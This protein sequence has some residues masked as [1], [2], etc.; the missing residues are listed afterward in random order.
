MRFSSIE[1][2]NYRQYRN[3]TLDFNKGKHDLHVIVG[4]NGTGKTNLLNAFTWCLYGIE[5]HLGNS[6]KHRGEPKLN[7]DTISDAL[8]R[9][10]DNATI[11]VEIELELDGETDR[12]SRKLPV[13]IKSK[14]DILEKKSSESF[15][16]QRMILGGQ[17]IVLRDEAASS[18]IERK[19]PE[20]IREYFFFD[21][22]QLSNYFSEVRS[23]AIKAAIHSIS[24]ID[25]VTRMRERTENTVKS[26][27]RGL[28]ASIPN[29]K[30]IN[31]DIEKYE[32]ERDAIQTQIDFL[33]EQSRK[34]KLRITELNEALRGV[35]DLAK[36]ESDRDTLRKRIAEC[37][38]GLRIAQSGLVSFT[39]SAFIDFA[40]Y[41]AANG[42]LGAVVNMEGERQLPPSIDRSYIEEML[43]DHVC[44]VCGRP[45]SEHDYSHLE[46]VL[47]QFKVSSETSHILIGMRSELRH[48]I[49][50]VKDYPKERDRRID[51]VK[52]AEASLN[53]AFTRLADV[54]H[55]IASYPDSALVK[56]WYTERSDLESTLASTHETIGVLKN[57]KAL[58]DSKLAKL[59][60]ELETVMKKQSKQQDLGE[61]IRFGSSAAK[62]LTEVES[63]VIT[64]VRL[65]MAS[66]TEALFKGLVWKDS[67]CDH[68]EL[69]ESYL[70]SLYDKTGYSC[71]ATCSA[72]ERALLALSFTLAMHEVS[73]F[74]S[75]LFIDT[76]IA[77][78][79]GENRANF[80]ATLAEVS[81]S[82]QLILTFTPDE[83]SE[84]ISSVFDP[85][86]SSSQ[87]LFLD[88][89]EQMVSVRS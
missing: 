86:S 34:A 15:M 2:K 19:L 45:L 23:G 61:A 53:D 57:K 83:Y 9:G 47:E 17:P 32:K 38:E 35:P 65:L 81:R 76:P 22:E 40:F 59:E 80:A 21:G 13:L 25:I 49:D 66:R 8:S 37:K 89:S 7:K 75:P 11:S 55:T 77:R 79:S 46:E 33:E 41:D 5:P 24:Q 27:R 85:I 20:G 54:E 16:V 52:R 29:A 70:L 63:D 1:I 14:T 3:L 31:D 36:C 6:D 64:E 28:D 71:A 87:H 69:S 78:A 30:E 42:A 51:E 43:H 68:I 72:A 39:R 82:K 58:R 4:D 12:I 50:R 26:M 44:K 62:I 18:Y 60:K 73:G 84:S 56:K 10:S 74:E 67:K 48:L 88:E